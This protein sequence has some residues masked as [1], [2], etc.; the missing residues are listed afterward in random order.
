MLD[1]RAELVSDR[2]PIALEMFS[3]TLR[4]LNTLPKNEICF[5][6]ISSTEY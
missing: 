6:L 5:S 1:P 2:P 3:V 4:S